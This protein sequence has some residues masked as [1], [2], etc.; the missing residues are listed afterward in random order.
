M[1]ILKDAFSVILGGDI[2]ELLIEPIPRLRQFFYGEG[3][4]KEFPLNLE[5]NDDVEI[6]RYFV[7]INSDR[8]FGYAIYLEIELI[9]RYMTQLRFKSLSESRFKLLPERATPTHL[10][11]PESALRFVGTHARRFP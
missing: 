4:V 10:V 8:I 5:S 3:S 9:T 11:L 7:G 2:Q 1:D 6:V